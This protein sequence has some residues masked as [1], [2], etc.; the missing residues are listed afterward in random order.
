MSKRTIEYEKT[1]LN[2]FIVA[3]P[4]ER[5]VEAAALWRRETRHGVQES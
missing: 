4:L 3:F 5:V 1:I 2:F